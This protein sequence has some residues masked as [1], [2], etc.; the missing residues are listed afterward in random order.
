MSLVTFGAVPT[1]ALCLSKPPLSLPKNS[2]IQNAVPPVPY[3][4]SP[5]MCQ[6]QTEKDQVCGGPLVQSS[7]E[8]SSSTPQASASAQS[9]E[10]MTDMLDQHDEELIRRW[11]EATCFTMGDRYELAPMWQVT[12]PGLA[13]SQ[14]FLRHG[15]L[16]LAAMHIRCTSPL[17]L[18]TKY[19]DLASQHQ[20][21]ALEGYIPQLENITAE[22]CHALFAFSALLLAIQYSFISVLDSEIDGHEYIAEVASVFEYV[23]GATVIAFEGEV[24]LRQGG[25]QPLM[26][27]GTEPRS[28]L[29]ELIEGPQNA[30]GSLL[31]YVHHLGDNPGLSVARETTAN[32][33]VYVRSIEMLTNAFPTQDTERRIFDDMIGWPHYV[34]ADLVRLLRAQD[35][36]ALAILAHYG[37]A[38]EA[39]RDIWWLEG[40]GARLV[41]AIA[42]V[43][44]LEFGP[45]VQ[46]PL[47]RVSVDLS[48][49]HMYIM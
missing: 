13:L 40:V 19:L 36:M 48:L 15:V 26:A 49:Q 33:P 4:V 28:I 25:M 47:E 5:R 45:L 16:A 39:F 11:S 22:N 35:Q 34:G 46:W 12:V 21:R 20:D 41:R 1:L 14:P 24:W 38:L 44:P 43:L 18:Q 23:I 9:L 17:P 32:I 30:L 2:M 6:L 31:S 8:S 42:R 10:H 3:Q 7:G 29:S 27:R 37:V